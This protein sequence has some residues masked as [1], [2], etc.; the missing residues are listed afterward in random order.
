MALSAPFRESE[1]ASLV[2]TEPGLA[3][4]QVG[5]R[6]PPSGVIGL[7]VV[8]V[9]VVAALFAN[10]LAPHDPTAQDLMVNL[11]PPGSPGFALGTD[12]LGRDVLSRLMYGARVSLI[13]G[14]AAVAVQGTIGTILGLLAGYFKGPA[15]SAIMR[16]ADLQLSIP[17]L[18][19]AIGVIAVVGPSL[20]NVILI[21]GITGWPYYGRLVRG[22]VLSVRERDFVLAARSSGC[23][24]GR[25]L[26]KHVFP[27]VT[28]SLIVSATFAVPLMI[29][30]EA[31]L[32]FLGLGVPPSIPSWGT[33][34]SD[35]RDFLSTAWWISTFPGLVIFATVVGINLLGDWLRDTLDPTH[36][37][38][39]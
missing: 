29:I 16:L 22:E 30:N 17:P 10:M 9:V 4:Q 21:L 6:L 11:K 24:S 1:L 31:A 34:V 15:E 37:G 36:Q 35:G 27:C 39:R 3:E 20:L 2:A 13:V 25:I 5:R 7:L 8:I 18:V 12:S 14:I 38:L 32:S 28:T 26:W 33:M 23:G 19:L